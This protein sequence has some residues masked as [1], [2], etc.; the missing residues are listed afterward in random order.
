MGTAACSTN[1]FLN[2]RKQI[3]MGVGNGGEPKCG[4]KTVWLVLMIVSLVLGGI[5]VI[6]PLAVGSCS[7]CCDTTCVLECRGGC[8]KACEYNYNSGCWEA[9]GAAFKSEGA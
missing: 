8:S 5:L 4:N 9:K 3:I 1:S 7:E 6:I 2:S